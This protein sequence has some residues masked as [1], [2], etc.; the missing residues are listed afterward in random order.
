MKFKNPCYYSLSALLLL[1]CFIL[2][3]HTIATNNPGLNFDPSI[4]TAL[5]AL[6]AVIFVAFSLARFKFRPW[7]KSLS[8]F[9]W[10][11]LFFGTVGILNILLLDP[12]AEGGAFWP[13]I[14]SL[15]IL[16]NY[17][18]LFLPFQH[19]GF[20]LTGNL[21]IG[22]C[23]F[24]FFKVLVM[25]GSL[26]GIPLI[27]QYLSINASYMEFYDLAVM[28][29][30]W[31]VGFIFYYVGISLLSS[32]INDENFQELSKIKE[33]LMI[34][35]IQMKFFGIRNA[36]LLGKSEAEIEDIF[37][38]KAIEME[39]NYLKS[40]KFLNMIEAKREESKFISNISGLLEN[41]AEATKNYGE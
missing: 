15:V 39:E 29:L 12:M 1:L 21:A 17:R 35:A 18:N 16:F 19:S 8:L 36:E 31:A 24:L 5:N 7:S 38:C 4:N 10:G 41:N 14:L 13:W 32:T 34:N 2:S 3:T 30:L 6:I 25:S 26:N 33:K 40:Q 28:S 22:A 37:I 23:I 27:G 11:G 9:A 20:R